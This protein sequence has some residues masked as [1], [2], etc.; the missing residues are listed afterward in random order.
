MVGSALYGTRISAEEMKY[1]GNHRE[2]EQYMDQE[3]RCMKHKEATEP[4]QSQY[5]SYS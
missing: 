4:Q 3:A 1:H 2:Y 5:N